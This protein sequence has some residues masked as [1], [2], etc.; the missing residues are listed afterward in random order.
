MNT[1]N[2]APIV[3]DPLLDAAWDQT[4]T[5]Y[6]DAT[7]FHTTAWIRVLLDTY[8]Y[9]TQ[10]V[11]FE[12]GTTD[13][14]TILLSEVNSSITGRRLVSL[15]FSDFCPPLT[16]DGTRLT[17]DRIRAAVGS[18]L[19]R[20]YR[21]VELRD[22]EKE[23]LGEPPT[24]LVHDLDLT[25]GDECLW[26]GIA[27]ST[28]RNV[29]KANREGLAVRFDLGSTAME[30][31]YRLHC[32]TRKKHGVPPQAWRF[33]DGIQ[34]HLIAPGNGFIASAVLRDTVLAANVYLTVGQSAVYKFGASDQRYLG[35]RP[36][37]LLMWESIRR[38]TS[39]GCH[40]L[41]FGRTSMHQAGLI[42]FKRAFGASERPMTYT[43]YTRRETSRVPGDEP[44][45]SRIV[46]SRMPVG[47]LRF[48]GR[49][50]YRHVG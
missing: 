33:F 27:S 14:W 42:R 5:Q 1:I 29:R 7:V 22:A 38:L 44:G 8:G 3:R 34:R 30:A 20:G 12:E 48:L 17:I 41:S 23:C 37:D 36:N 6:Q 40:S 4:L 11:T 18:W 50:L 24:F 28:R 16:R 26:S 31:F 21:Y 43:R 45:V 2:D 39:A 25:K 49:L 35:Y 13:E 32:Q 19:T 9:R 46:L 47:V 10:S 15:P